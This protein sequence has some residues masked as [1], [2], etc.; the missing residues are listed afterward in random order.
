MLTTSPATIPSPSD[1]S[2]VERD[3]HLAG[4]DRDADV[5]VERR[6]G[7]VQLLDGVARGERRAHGAL[8]VVLVR[9]RCAEDGH[10]RVADELLHGAAEALDLGAQARV[11]RGEHRAH[12]LRVELLGAAG[13]ADEV[14]EEDRDDLALLTP[15][16]LLRGERRAARHAEARTVRVFRAARGAIHALQRT[17]P[18]TRLRHGRNA[19]RR[20]TI[21]P[22]RNGRPCR[23]ASRA[24]ASG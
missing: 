22:K 4:V 20:R 24:R 8:G 3:D 14:G 17:L 1:G 10:D 7:L 23:R 16:G 9:D 12:V 5:Q 19:W 18:R 21:S 15:A 11:V 2:S 6:V 13:E